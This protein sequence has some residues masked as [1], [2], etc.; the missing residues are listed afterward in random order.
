MTTSSTTDAIVDG[1]KTMALDHHHADYY[2]PDDS[3]SDSTV[4]ATAKDLSRHTT[5]KR[6]DW[7]DE[8]EHSFE[9]SCNDN[10]YTLDDFNAHETT[11]MQSYL[12]PSCLEYTDQPPAPRQ[13]SKFSV[14]KSKVKR[15]FCI[16]SPASNHHHHSQQQQV[17]MQSSLPVFPTSTTRNSSVDTRWNP[18]IDSSI[19]SSST[20]RPPDQTSTHSSNSN[21]SSSKSYSCGFQR[22]SSSSSAIVAAQKPPQRHSTVSRIKNRFSRT[23]SLGTLPMSVPVPP[24]KGILKKQTNAATSTK[25]TKTMRP[26]LS[27]PA[28]ALL[29]ANPRQPHQPRKKRWST[30][31]FSVYSSNPHTK[32]RYSVFSVMNSDKRRSQPLQQTLIPTE[33]GRVHFNMYLDVQETYAKGDYDRSSDPDAVC[34][35]LT[36]VTA[37]QIKRELN[38]FKLHEMEVHDYSREYTHFF[39]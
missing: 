16:A 4:T 23:P 26:S 8:I 25:P 5:E 24:I 20:L 18:S 35:R 39:T 37:T 14:I 28:S 17:L 31:R 11:I 1:I 13:K 21:A 34:N 19:C 38:Y 30:T 27:R 9:S 32:K 33:S 12:E 22:S 7:M 6:N 15:V 36:A 29:P 3:T 10:N 2:Y